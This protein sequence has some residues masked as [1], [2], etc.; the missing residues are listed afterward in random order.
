MPQPA[1]STILVNNG[2]LTKPSTLG[3]QCISICAMP[4]SITISLIIICLTFPSLHPTSAL[5]HQKS[6]LSSS[7]S[8][9]DF[10]ELFIQKIGF[11]VSLFFSFNISKKIVLTS[12]CSDPLDSSKVTH[13]YG[14]IREQFSS[15]SHNIFIHTNVTIS[16]QKRH[17][18][19]ARSTMGLFEVRI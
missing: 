16:S 15:D 9:S 8:C 17:G 3:K 10:L 2:L 11:L 7:L 14:H 18:F 1:E 12:S 19:T 6:Q 5:V 4:R 13:P